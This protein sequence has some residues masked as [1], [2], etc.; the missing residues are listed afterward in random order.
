MAC[1]IFNQLNILTGDFPD[2]R[3]EGEQ[4]QGQVRRVP[5]DVGRERLD[6]RSRPLRMVPVVLQVLPGNL[7]LKYNLTS[8][9]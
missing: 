5:P 4:V 3:R 9:L 6:Q 7:L 8:F 2:L 1:T